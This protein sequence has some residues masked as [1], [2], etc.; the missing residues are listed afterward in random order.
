MKNLI[1]GQGIAGTLVAYQLLKAGEEVMVVDDGNMDSSSRIAAGMFTPVSGKRMTLTPNANQLMEEAI[2]TYLELET[3]LG[4]QFVNLQPIYH[5]FASVK[6]QNDLM[7]RMDNPLFASY[8][9]PHPQKINCIHQPYGAFEVSRSGW[10]HMPTL[11]TAFREKLKT[12]KSLTEGAFHYDELIVSDEGFKYQNTLY[13]RVVFCEGIK[14]KD[15]P[16]FTDIEIIPCK[17]DVLTIEC[18]DGPKDKIAKKGCYMVNTHDAIYRVGSTYHWGEDN[19]IPDQEGFDQLNGK[20]KELVNV[21]YEIVSH[22]VGVRPT[23]KTREPIL[24]QHAT[25][26]NMFAL[27]GLGTKGVLHAPVQVKKLLTLLNADGKTKG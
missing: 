16:F 4:V 3:F 9:N 25:F 5:A 26:K 27:N 20:L 10:L 15:N 23:T 11:L 21:D 2:K 14:I 24:K 19:L 1:V 8:V 7:S 22:K 17:G 6:E 18:K 12:L 13:N